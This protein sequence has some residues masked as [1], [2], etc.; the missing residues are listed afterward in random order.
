MYSEMYDAWEKRE[1]DAAFNW[2]SGAR[3]FAGKLL[4]KGALYV[5]NFSGSMELK[6]FGIIFASVEL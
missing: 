2:G 1:C 5:T 3:G 6:R 4:E